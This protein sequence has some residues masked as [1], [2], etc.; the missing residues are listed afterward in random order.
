MEN[1]IEDENNNNNQIIFDDTII[2]DFLKNKL[3]KLFK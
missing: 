3:I 2:T 1:K